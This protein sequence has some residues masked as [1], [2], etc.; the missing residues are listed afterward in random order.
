MKRFKIIITIFIILMGIGILRILYIRHY[1]HE[2]SSKTVFD[3]YNNLF[4]KSAQEKLKILSTIQS[5]HREPE[6]NYV[7]DSSYNVFVFRVKLA[8]S[9]ELEK[10]INI[11][12]ENSVISLKAVYRALPSPDNFEID[13]KEGKTDSVAKLN[14]RFEGSP[15]RTIAKNDSVICQYLKFKNMSVSYND[16]NTTYDIIA[17]VNDSRDIPISV[18]F[19]KR[20]GFLYIMLLTQLTTNNEFQADLLYKITN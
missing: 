8:D 12:N 5:K 18:E 11:K 2:T 13:K 1:D 19:I 10:I 15:I 17:K 3:A 6:S 9:I 16:D 7:Y 4:S 14:Y 20:G